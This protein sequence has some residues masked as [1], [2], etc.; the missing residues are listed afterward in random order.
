MKK[1]TIQD[2][3]VGVDKNGNPLWLI[4]TKEEDN[5]LSLEEKRWLEERGFD[6]KE[7]K[8]IGGRDEKTQR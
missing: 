8:R 3:P 7:F 4:T 2:K 5:E 6:P 1:I